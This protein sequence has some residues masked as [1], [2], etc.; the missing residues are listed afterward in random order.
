MGELQVRLLHPLKCSLVSLQKSHLALGGYILGW[1]AGQTSTVGVAEAG[2]VV[3]PLMNLAVY[4]YGRDSC[5]VARLLLLIEDM[6]VCKP[7]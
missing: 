4:N 2:L 6:H 3:A 7:S 1:E 5:Q